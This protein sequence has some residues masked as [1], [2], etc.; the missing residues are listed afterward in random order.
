MKMPGELVGSPFV[1]RIKGQPGF[2]LTGIVVRDLRV[3]TGDGQVVRQQALVVD[4]TVV[5]LL[6]SEDSTQPGP[7]TVSLD[8]FLSN[9]GDWKW[10]PLPSWEQYDAMTTRQKEIND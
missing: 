8:G 7:Q 9:R 4:A 2:Q 6:L 10:P 3:Q 5:R 1:S